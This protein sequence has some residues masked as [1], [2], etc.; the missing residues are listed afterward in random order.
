MCPLESDIS[1]IKTFLNKMWPQ[2]LGMYIY[3]SF[4]FE[5]I[6][7]VDDIDVV[8]LVRSNRPQRIVEIFEGKE[9]H[10]NVLSQS[11]FLQDIEESK[12]G[13]YYVNKVMNPYLP[14]KETRQLY[15][16]FSIAR[17]VKTLNALKLASFLKIKKCF[18]PNDIVKL[19][20]VI[21]LLQFPHYLGPAITMFSNTSSPLFLNLVKEYELA[22][23]TLLEEGVVVKKRSNMYAFNYQVMEEDLISEVTRFISIVPKY[24]KTFIEVHGGNWSSVESYLEKHSEKLKKKLTKNRKVSKMLLKD[25]L[26][27]TKKI[28]YV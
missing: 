6:S 9:M 4:I 16:I 13:E 8:V 3:G 7:E 25:I 23:N 21:R 15:K 28:N 1:K 2:N 10:I 14:L 11:V 26:K 17:R 20:T 12:F 27:I 22:L 19:V 18:C 5:R 24:W